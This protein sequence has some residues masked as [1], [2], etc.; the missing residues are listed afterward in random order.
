MNP[1]SVLLAAILAVSS[2]LVNAL[3]MKSYSDEDFNA[4]QK[5]KRPVAVQFHAVW[6][7]TCWAQ[8]KS[9]DSLRSDKSLDMTLLVANYDLERSL[10]KRLNVT[11]QS[12][13]VVF[14]D[15]SEAARSSGE[16]E[17]AD[18]KTLLKKAL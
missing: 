1:R 10:K 11:R 6:C 9:L 12:T 13:V 16:T 18:L 2:T 3:E 8:K 7:S 14:K 17:A 15:G 5:A 4:L